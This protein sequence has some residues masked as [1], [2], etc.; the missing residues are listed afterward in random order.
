MLKFSLKAVYFSL[1]L[2]SLSSCFMMFIGKQT[3]FT[4]RLAEARGL[5]GLVADSRNK[6]ISIYNSR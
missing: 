5:Y 3:S 1:Q 6:K 2:S 4:Y